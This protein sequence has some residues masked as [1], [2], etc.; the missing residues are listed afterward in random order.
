M[1]IT[2]EPYE[3]IISQDEKSAEISEFLEFL[4]GEGKEVF[5]KVGAEVTIHLDREVE[6]KYTFVFPDGQLPIQVYEEITEL[7]VIRKKL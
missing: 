7:K 1:V 6:N 2:F 5:D 3:W 4:G